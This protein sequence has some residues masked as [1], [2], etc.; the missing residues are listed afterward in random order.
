MRVGGGV[1]PDALAC[2]RR[3][4]AIRLR[5]HAACAPQGRPRGRGKLA[6]YHAFFEELVA[7]DPDITLFELRAGVGGRR[8]GPPF[9]NCCTAVAPRVHVQ[10]KSLVA[11][12]RRRAK[13]RRARRNWQT[14]RMPAMRAQPEILVFIDETSVKTNLTRLRGRAPRAAAADERAVRKLG[15][16]DIHH[17]PDGRYADGAMAD[18]GCDR[19]VRLRRLCPR[20]AGAGTASRHCRHPRQTCP[21]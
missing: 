18:K 8:R 6:P 4:W 19:R 3:A 20:G 5:G 16:T 15:H 11:T 21:A 10:K 13:A 12:E 17:R 7:Q 9:L 2:G 1:A 14:H